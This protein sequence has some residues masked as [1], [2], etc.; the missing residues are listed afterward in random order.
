MVEVSNIFSFVLLLILSIV[1]FKSQA[2]S[3]NRINFASQTLRPLA[4][5]PS[6]DGSGHGSSPGFTSQKLGTQEIIPLADGTLAGGSG[7]GSS[8]DF[9]S[10][11]L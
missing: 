11:N 6:T 9:I 1:L 2:R 8:P 5:G 3:I 7:R 10:H 4:D